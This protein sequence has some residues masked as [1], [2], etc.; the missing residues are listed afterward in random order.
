MID[1]SPTEEQQML[2]DAIRRYAANDLQ[3]K[4][5]EMDENSEIPANIINKGWEIGLL[6]ASIPEELGGF[7]EY[8]AVTNVLA[9]EELAYGDLAAALKLMTPA[10]FAFP[11]LHAGTEDQKGRFL[12]MFVEEEPFPATAALIEP[13]ITFDPLDL[14]T[15]ATRNN[16]HICLQGHK[17]YVPN[18]EGA[19]WILV[20]A[21][22]S[23]T[24][25][26]GGYM[27]E[28]GAD[29][30]EIQEREK[31]MG[32][33]GLP[34]YRV[35][36]NDVRVED[37]L[38][39]GGPE[40]IDF[41]I[42]LSHMNLALSAMAVGVM[43]ASYEYAKNYAKERV[44]FGQPIATKQA[45]AFMLAEAAIEVESSRMMTWEAAW[46][47]DNAEATEKIT[48]AV[49]LAKHYTDQAVLQV[50]DAGVQVLGGHGF[51]REHPVE[52][53]LRNGR[54][55]PMFTGLAFA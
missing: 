4:A 37:E 55:F 18:A 34:T 44:Q 12:P 36:L 3:A 25:K 49:Y 33:R 24:G 32:I 41:S 43:R 7:G 31:L 42:L 29:N 35:N 11:V 30:V 40:G 51:I 50:T 28:A 15:T 45:I 53:W 14:T 48:Q 26:V 1:F 27:V 23:E 13:S 17:A 38:I 19:K 39:L 16:G 9:Y 54:G 20:Y 10:L 21:R 46:Q 52:R 47:L 2:T 22:D 8:S 6:P 5:H